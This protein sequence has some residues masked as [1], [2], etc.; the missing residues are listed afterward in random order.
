[1][2]EKAKQKGPDTKDTAISR[3]RTR[4]NM[5]YI[6]TKLKIQN[7]GKNQGKNDSKI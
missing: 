4:W 6:H 7:N 1:M 2:E 5:T 3:T